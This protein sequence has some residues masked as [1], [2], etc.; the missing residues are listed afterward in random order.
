MR[1]GGVGGLSGREGLC[2]THKH[3]ITQSQSHTQC[4]AEKDYVSHTNTQSQSQSHTM[5][6][7]EE[8]GLEDSFLNTG[9][10]LN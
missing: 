9:C 3:T 5:S 6:G 7:R 10:F 4:Q 8:L 2:L 1:G